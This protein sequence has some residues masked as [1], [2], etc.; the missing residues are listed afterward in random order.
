VTWGAGYP[1]ARTQLDEPAVQALLRAVDGGMG[2][3][4][5]RVP[6]AGGSLPLYHLQEV[7]GAPFVMLP[8]VNHDNNQHGENE[9][10]RLQNL[11]DGIEL[12]ASLLHRIGREW[13]VP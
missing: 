6:T 4:L 10:L 1:A 13:Q 12:F 5:I 8:M 9:N 3:R 7:L 2:R 11:W